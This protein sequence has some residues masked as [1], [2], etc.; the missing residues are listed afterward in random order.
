MIDS[1]VRASVTRWKTW[2]FQRIREA[3]L[4]QSIP[5]GHFFSK[6]DYLEIMLQ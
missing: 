2:L 6:R 1:T 4:G 3:Y 5:Y